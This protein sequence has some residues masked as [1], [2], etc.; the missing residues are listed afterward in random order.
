MAL[1]N[2][3]SPFGAY[4]RFLEALVT[5]THGRSF[6]LLTQQLLSSTLQGFG[7]LLIIP[8]LSLAGIATGS[9]QSSGPLHELQQT[10]ARLGIEIQ[11]IHILALYAVAITLLSALKRYHSLFAERLQQTFVAQLGIDLTKAIAQA[12]WIKLAQAKHSELTQNLS[13]DL[14][15]IHL[16]TLQTFQLF[17][18]VTLFIINLVVAALISL[19]LLVPSLLAIGLLLFAFRPLHRRSQTL[20]KHYRRCREAYFD[21]VNSLL[22]GIKLIKAHGAEDDQIEGFRVISQNSVTQSLAFRRA[23]A[24]TLWLFESSAAI[25]L[26]LFVYAASTWLQLPA[27]SILLLV[28]LYARTLPLVTRVQQS[29]QSIQHAL[30]SFTSYENTLQRFA[31]TTTRNQNHSTLPSE[32]GHPSDFAFNTLSLRNVSFAYPQTPERKILDQLNLSL[33]ARQTAAIMGPSGCG[34]STLSDILCGLILPESGQLLLDEHP[35]TP[36][37]IPAWQRRIA[38]VPQDTFLFHDSLRANLLWAKPTATE[39]ELW[40]ALE[41]AHA[42]AFVRQLPQTLDTLV[43]DRGSRLSGGERQRIALARALIRKPN[44]LILD[45]ATNALDKDS[46]AQIRN[47]IKTLHGELTILIITH[48]PNTAAQADR[49]HCIENGAAVP[50]SRPATPKHP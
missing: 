37:Q 3:I 2:D 13:E 45:E 39:E 25:G 28:F 24:T 33:K 22:D 38:Y 9:P 40:A 35:L 43:G 36:D 11:L 17:S 15:Q 26:A 14:K 48:D 21:H 29:W 46:E 42:A 32:A 27:A 5:R 8:L 19:P 23:H 4:R 41:L 44:L 31:P 50:V 1:P 12:P 20:G 47:A 6:W 7:L 49:I 30:P 18:G 16:A 10:A 34:K